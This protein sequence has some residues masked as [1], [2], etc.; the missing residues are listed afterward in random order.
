MPEAA[1][2]EAAP[3]SWVG[4]AADEATT[5]AAMQD[6]VLQGAEAEAQAEQVE[7]HGA[8]TAEAGSSELR[9]ARM[10]AAEATPGSSGQACSGPEVGDER[11]EMRRQQP[12]TP[13]TPSRTSAPPPARCRDYSHV[14][15]PLDGLWS[16]P[17]SL[18]TC[19][20]ARQYVR[21][22]DDQIQ[23]LVLGDA[24]HWRPWP[25]GTIT[26]TTPTWQPCSPPCWT[27][28][29]HLRC[30]QMAAVPGRRRAMTL[31]WT[32]CLQRLPALTG[33]R[34]RGRRPRGVSWGPCPCACRP[35]HVRRL[36]AAAGAMANVRVRVMDGWHRL[37][38]APCTHI[39]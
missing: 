31:T 11:A 18:L 13:P 24:G 8:L 12:Q 19:A 16:S 14:A 32:A 38:K 23:G 36:Q 10:E 3:L 28:A 39:I 35:A 20:M 9:G 22:Q 1:P 34:R 7:P 26:T 15:A 30:R 2:A 5:S 29:T 17:D 25:V 6:S 27:P 37:A 4:S 21:Y 33:T